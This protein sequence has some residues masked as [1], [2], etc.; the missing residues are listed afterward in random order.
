MSNERFIAELE[1]IIGDFL[2]ERGMDLVELAY[3]FEGQGLVLRVMADYPQGG[4]TMGEC[5]LLNRQI[6]DMLEEMQAIEGSY[7]LEVCSP[8]LDRP[9]RTGRDFR[10]CLSRAVKC[11]LK[12]PINGKI[13]WDGVIADVSDTLVVLKTCQGS[14][15]IPLDKINKAKQIIG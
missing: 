2:N 14:M 3:R 13:E 7:I 4:I 6:G 8:G 12:E 10:R 9:L 5:S 1:K 11:F 15:D